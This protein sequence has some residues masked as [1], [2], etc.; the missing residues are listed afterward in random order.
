VRPTLTPTRACRDRASPGATRDSLAD[1]IR[2]DVPAVA[3]VVV[4]YNTRDMTVDCIRSI[5]SQTR[6][7]CRIIVVDNASTDGSAAAVRDAFPDVELIAL[8]ENIGFARANN[9]A[10]RRCTEEFV[11]LLNPDTVVLDGAIDRLLRFTADRPGA[12]IWGGRTRFADGSLN[13]ASCWARMTPWSVTCR[14]LGL[15]RAFPRRTVFNPEAMGGWDRAQERSVDIVSGCFFLVRRSVWDRLAGFDESFFMYGEEA[16]LCLRARRIGC[17]PAV[18]PDAEIVHYG[19]ASERHRTEKAIRLLAAKVTL[20]R[21]HWPRTTRW[22]GLG[23]YT[24]WAGA[25]ALLGAVLG[26]T[27]ASAH[28]GC[29]WRA[30]WRRRA[31]WS[32]G[33]PTGV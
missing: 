32:A 17:S 22:Y 15:T 9:L 21:R 5:R 16:D 10:V 2:S 8:E 20:I 13:P 12:G 28:A 27:N 33:Y 6:T 31:E 11:L 23:A 7:P 30:V 26:I 3:V 1:W 18:T 25:R 29:D 24:A 4:S 14:V 19:G